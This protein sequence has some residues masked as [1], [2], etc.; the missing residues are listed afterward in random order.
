MLFEGF[1]V[2]RKI[3]S[4]F[5]IGLLTRQYTLSG[6]VLRWASGTA[7]G[8][9]IVAHLLPAANSASALVPGLNFIP[10]IAA[11]LQ[12]QNLSSKIT[13]LTDVTQLN[14]Y[15]TLQL[16][17]QVTSLSKVTQ[18]MFHLVSGATILSGLSLAVSTIGFIVINHK[19]N[20]IDARLQEIQ[21][22]VQAIREFL[23]LSERAALRAAIDDL[24]KIDKIKDQQHRHTILHNARKTLSQ[25]KHKYSELLSRSVSVESAVANEEYF[26]LTALAQVRCTAELGMLDIARGE[27]ED[28]RNIW[29]T[30]AH[31]IAKDILIGTYPE[32]FLASDFAQDVPISAMVT[33]L[34]F[35]NEEPKGYLW[36][37]EIRQK[38]VEPWYGKFFDNKFGLNQGKGI[39]L[40]KEKTMVIPTLQKLIAR[41][42]IF[43]GFSL[44]YEILESQDITP[45][46]FER[47][48]A[49]HPK[50]TA[51]N[52]Y[53]V[54]Q[55]ITDK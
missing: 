55:P 1:T 34:D 35:A 9:Q 16:S 15:H 30:H 31:R 51:I 23:E 5:A 20:A 17:Q 40:E 13:T 10:G 49:E 14:L 7:K 22:Q 26:A 50:D 53:Y 42:G 3:P 38:M 18:Q 28:A 2:L 33:W 24:L 4:D 36:I 47:R 11:N 43:D 32:R 54:L 48:L 46:E 19:L 37:D 8:G 6:G 21:Q 45:S 29:T 44:Q 27:F 39:G 41:N 25:I 12:L 52:G